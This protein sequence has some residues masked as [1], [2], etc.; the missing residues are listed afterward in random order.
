MKVLWVKSGGLLPLDTGGKIRSFQLAKELARKHQVTLFTFYPEHASDRHAE[1]E[2][3][4]SRVVHIPMKLAHRASFG[5]CVNYAR[6]F[7][8]GR[9]HAMTKYCR[10]EIAK[11]FEEQGVA[12]VGGTPEEF[13]VFVTRELKRWRDAAQAANVKL[14]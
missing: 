13:G 9:P 12:R 1:L 2:Q 11:K 4:F 5:D 6:N 8:S 10:P 7:F 14:E 3:I